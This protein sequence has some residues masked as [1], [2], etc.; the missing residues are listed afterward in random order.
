[1]KIN[2]FLLLSLFCYSVQ[3]FAPRQVSS[4]SSSSGKSSQV[5]GMALSKFELVFIMSFLSP[6]DCLAFQRAWRGHLQRQFRYGAKLIEQGAEGELN[7]NLPFVH[8]LPSLGILSNRLLNIL[9]SQCN[10]YSVSYSPMLD[11]FVSPA[12]DIDRDYRVRLPKPLQLLMII[13]VSQ[14]KMVFAVND[15]RDKNYK[16]CVVNLESLEVINEV[17]SVIDLGPEDPCHMSLSRSGQYSV[18]G[19]YESGRI[20]VFNMING[21]LVREI[22]IGPNQLS[23]HRQDSRLQFYRQS[24]VSRL[25]LSADGKLL[26]VVGPRS[27]FSDGRSYSRSIIVYGVESGDVVQIIE[28]PCST[29]SSIICARFVGQTNDILALYYQPPLPCDGE[30]T[31][32][33]DREEACRVPC[34]WVLFKWDCQS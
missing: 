28:S 19:N 9:I 20:R 29:L 24:E 2:L 32:E 18:V 4:S 10:I 31:D 11:T 15:L 1:M 25:Q 30:D 3:L 34:L 5:N 8:L 23:R 33:M 27:E 26:L 14:D 21:S 13:G 22:N 7:N 12:G 17:S 6:A 16:L